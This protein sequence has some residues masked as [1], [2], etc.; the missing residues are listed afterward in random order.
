M[1]LNTN[2]FSSS[3]LLS[4]VLDKL[5]PYLLYL[6]QKVNHHLLYIYILSYCKGIG[7]STIGATIGGCFRGDKPISNERH[8]LKAFNF[9]NKF[10]LRLTIGL[11]KALYFSKQPNFIWKC[12]KNK[13]E[14]NLVHDREHC[15]PKIWLIRNLCNKLSW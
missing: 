11:K 5:S 2:S 4:L 13:P 7:Q 6:K 15:C 3:R 14:S 9:L 12:M 1:S 8:F 10:S